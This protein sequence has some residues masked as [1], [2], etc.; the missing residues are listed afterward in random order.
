MRRFPFEFSTA[1]SLVTVIKKSGQHQDIIFVTKLD[2]WQLT[3]YCKM[4]SKLI[5]STALTKM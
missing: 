4:G 3:H 1:L 5:N 2:L